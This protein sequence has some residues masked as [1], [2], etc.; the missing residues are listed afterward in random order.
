LNITGQDSFFITFVATWFS[1]RILI[2]SSSNDMS[3]IT[4]KDIIPLF[5]LI[6]GLFS[7]CMINSWVRL[8]ISEKKILYNQSLLIF[9]VIGLIITVTA[10]SSEF[11]G[12]LKG[13]DIW[14]LIA[15]LVLW[16]FATIIEDVDWEFKVVNRKNT[17][18]SPSGNNQKKS[19]S[20][21]VTS[22]T[23]VSNEK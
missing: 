20:E 5:L 8:C 9:G 12:Y 2:W 13:P 10:H 21:M 1:V 22:Q 14:L 3:L 11:R 7:Y 23:A 4:Y 17:S 16:L 6:V 18:N 19:N 15:V